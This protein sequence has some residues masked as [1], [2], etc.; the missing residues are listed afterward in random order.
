MVEYSENVVANTRV[1]G[2]R[3]RE[4]VEQEIDRAKS[5]DT[6]AGAVIAASVALIGVSVAFVLQLV[7]QEA[8]MGARVLWA[9]VSRTGFHGDRFSWF[10]I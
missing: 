3:A 5:L 7:D 2:E 9:V 10:P 4:I 1:Y 8:G 6:K